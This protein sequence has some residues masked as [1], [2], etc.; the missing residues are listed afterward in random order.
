VRQAAIGAT[1]CFVHGYTAEIHRLAAQR[2][3][4]LRSAVRVE[5]GLVGKT[6]NFERLGASDL[7]PIN[8]RHAPTPILNPVHSRR[9]V[10]FSDRGGAILKDPQC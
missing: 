6:Y 7:Q 9:R 4:K 10:T 2:A 5:T 1:P 3:S 8:A